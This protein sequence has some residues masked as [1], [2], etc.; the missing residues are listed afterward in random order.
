M[1]LVNSAAYRRAASTDEETMEPFFFLGVPLSP[2]E[3][4]EACRLAK[5]G[6]ERVCPFCPA[7]SKFENWTS[8]IWNS[9]CGPLSS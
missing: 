5:A 6:A 2:G 1:S 3:A 8:G 4:T 7:T 9:V